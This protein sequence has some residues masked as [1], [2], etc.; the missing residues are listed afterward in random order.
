MLAFRL[1]AAVGSL[2]PVSMWYLL[3]YFV[4]SKAWQLIHGNRAAE[5]ARTNLLLAKVLLP[6]FFILLWIAA[7]WA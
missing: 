5:A 6:P 4:R 7:L 1:A 3:G 2:I